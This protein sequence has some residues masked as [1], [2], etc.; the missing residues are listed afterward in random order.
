MLVTSYPVPCDWSKP[1]AEG[2]RHNMATNICSDVINIETTLSETFKPHTSSSSSDYFSQHFE[3][4]IESV[5]TPTSSVS[6]SHS[7]IGHRD[8][9]YEDYSTNGNVNIGLS[10]ES[11]SSFPCHRVTFNDKNEVASQD[12]DGSFKVTYSQLG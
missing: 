3:N 11:S 8:I 9:N 6:S 4:A 5:P 1:Q 10:S 12:L 7:S 2:E